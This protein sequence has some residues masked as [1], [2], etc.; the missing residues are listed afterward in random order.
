MAFKSNIH[1]GSR[2]MNHNV[3][4][5]AWKHQL[6]MTFLYN[7]LIEVTKSANYFFSQ[8]HFILLLEWRSP[9]Q[10]YHDTDRW[11]I[12]SRT[13]SENLVQFRASCGAEK[14]HGKEWKV[15]ACSGLFWREKWSHW[16]RDDVW[17]SHW[18]PC[19]ICKLRPLWS[20]SRDLRLLRSRS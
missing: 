2:T 12:H 1:V 4:V 3:K 14:I 5:S 11:R 19:V 18:P 9:F 17:S 20:D 6:Y 10:A 7:F 13:S 8:G 16:W 15:T